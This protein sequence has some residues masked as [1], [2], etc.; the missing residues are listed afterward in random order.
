MTEPSDQPADPW[1]A[2]PPPAAPPAGWAVPGYGSP[3]AGQ[4][5]Q[6]PWGQPHPQAG[7]GQPYPPQAYGQPYGYPAQPPYGYAPAAGNNGLAIAS[8]VCSFFGFVYGIPA[9]LAIVFGFVARSQIRQRPQGG[10]GMALAGIIIGFLWVGLM[11][12]GAVALIA[13]GAGSTGS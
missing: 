3:A 7:Y 10:A 12:L 6:Q 1:A 2:T 8:L 5:P 11:V 9:I 4:P 13:G